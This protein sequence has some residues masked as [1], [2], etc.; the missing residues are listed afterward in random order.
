MG[1]AEVVLTDVLVIGDEVLA[2]PR[3]LGAELA[4]QLRDARDLGVHDIG[5]AAEHAVAGVG[6][7][8]EGA[9]VQVLV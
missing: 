8:F 2:E 1:Q 4:G 6:D 5:R 7:D 3:L 9:A